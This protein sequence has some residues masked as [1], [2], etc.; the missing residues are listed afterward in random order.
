[1]QTRTNLFLTIQYSKNSIK[2]LSKYKIKRWIIS[3]LSKSAILNIRFVN[4]KEGLYLNKKFLGKNY[5]PNVLTFSYNEYKTDHIIA[6]IIICNEIL[7]TE[8]KKRN[9]LAIDH[10]AHLIIHGVLHACGLNHI[11]KREALKMEKIEKKILQK[12]NIKNPY[13]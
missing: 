13:A 11:K 7:K 8:A 9:I 5:A 10:A 2:N 3:A 6:D 12:F 1:M 4:N